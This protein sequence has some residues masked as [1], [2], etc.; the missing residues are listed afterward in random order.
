LT[1]LIVLAALLS[2]EANPAFADAKLEGTNPAQWRLVWNSDP[3]TSATVA[4]NTAE[5]GETHRVLLRKADVEKDTVIEAERNGRYSAKSPDLFFHPV[6]LTDHEQATKY[7]VTIESDGKQSPPMYFFTAPADDVPVSF[8]FGADSRSGHKERRQVN[9]MLAKMLAESYAGDRVPISAFA[10]GGD[11]VYDGR[12]L[13]QWSRWMSDHE[14]TTAADGQLLPIVPARGNHDGGEMFNEIF[15]FPPGDAD[16]YAF[17]LGSQ[18]RLITLNTETSLSGDQRKWL[19][20]ELETYR[21]QRRWLVP[22]YHRPAWPAVKWPWLNQ[23]QWVPLF[24]QY[25]V[26]LVCE[27]D[28]HNIKRTVPIRDFKADPTGVVYI[29]EGGLGVGQRTPKVDRWYLSSPDANAGE[30]HH[31]QLLTFDK[32]KITYRVVMLGGEIYDE[33][34]IPVRKAE[35]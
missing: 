10:H 14:L 27:G 18:V 7:L 8:V 15:A 32:E 19:Q 4:W 20:S 17:D 12:N 1:A 21:P 16:Y 3:A 28:G 6:N 13:E 23:G 11:F 30:G 22:Q 33:H 31:V 29:G 26:D 35:K 2:A 34:F 24:E 25:N 9:A 5:A